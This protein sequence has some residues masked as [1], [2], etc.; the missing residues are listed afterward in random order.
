MGS[1]SETQLR[2]LQE[3]NGKQHELVKQE[4]NLRKKVVDLLRQNLT[5]QVS[6]LSVSK[7]SCFNI[8]R[9]PEKGKGTPQIMHCKKR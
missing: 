3:L 1:L 7:D 2:S 4:V 9:R 6:D 5:E 8:G